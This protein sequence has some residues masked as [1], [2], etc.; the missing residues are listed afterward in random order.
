MVVFHHFAEIN[1]VHVVAGADL[2]QFGSDA[3]AGADINLA[4][5]KD[6][7]GNHRRLA[8]PVRGPKHLAIR[9]GEAG[10]VLHGQLDVL[11]GAIVA[12]G[13]DRGVLGPVRKVLT[14]PNRLASLGV[15]RHD[16]ALGTTRRTEDFVPVHKHRFG[17]TPAGP[18]AAELAHRPLPKG[19][20]IGRIGADQRPLP[21]HIVY[22]YG[23]HRWSAA[24]AIAPVVPERIGDFGLP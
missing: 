9:R 7:R 22:W 12:R 21:A 18:V 6:R 10:D 5:L 17:V 19:L 23:V 14:L 2:D 8:G 20:A 1:V 4:V 24:R 13:D 11:A 16:R 15:Q 3:I